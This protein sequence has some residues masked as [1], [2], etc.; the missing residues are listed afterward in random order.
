KV[1]GLLGLTLAFSII[2]MLLISRHI[3]SED[4]K[5]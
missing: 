4:D 2:Q 5:T 1:F 3:V